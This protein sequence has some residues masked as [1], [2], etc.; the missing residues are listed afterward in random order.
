MMMMITLAYWPL[1]DPASIGSTR[2]RFVVDDAVAAAAR[3]RSRVTE[4]KVRRQRYVPVLDVTRKATH[5]L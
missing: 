5:H 4:S 1:S 3:V 2:Q